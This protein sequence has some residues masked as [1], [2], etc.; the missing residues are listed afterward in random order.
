MVD[1]LDVAIQKAEQKCHEEN[2]SWRSF[3]VSKSPWVYKGSRNDITKKARPVKVVEHVEQQANHTTDMI[4]DSV[5]A[6]TDEKERDK[7]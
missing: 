3:S 2:L 4:L 5:E 7:K 1:C 6:Q